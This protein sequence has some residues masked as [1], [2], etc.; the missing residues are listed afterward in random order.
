MLIQD[1]LINNSI[2][3]SLFISQRTTE[4]MQESRR[5]KKRDDIF[6]K[7]VISAKNFFYLVISFSHPVI[8]FSASGEIV[9]SITPYSPIVPYCDV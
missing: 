8:T 7:D 5:V 4:K 6:S 9:S 1:F 3:N 2:K